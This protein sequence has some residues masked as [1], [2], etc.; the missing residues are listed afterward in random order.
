MSE[1][2][3]AFPVDHEP[4]NRIRNHGAI[5]LPG[6]KSLICQ[7][8]VKHRHQENPFCPGRCTTVDIWNPADQ[9]RLVVHEIIYIQGFI[10]PRW[11]S[12]NFWTINST[13]ITPFETIEVYII[14]WYQ[15]EGY[16][17]GYA[18]S[19]S[20]TWFGTSYPLKMNIF[21]Q[22]MVAYRMRPRLM[23]I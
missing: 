23:Y 10:H 5:T 11:W 12:P 9:L 18:S 6:K 4:R 14:V 3:R 2:L 8:N 1:Y 20:T 15:S 21:V 22:Q 17:L 7:P 19:T 16:I 13:K